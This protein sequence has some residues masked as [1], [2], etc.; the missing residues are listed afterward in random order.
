MK[1]PGKLKGC[2]GAV[3]DTM[4]IIYL[5]ENHEKYG[6]VVEWLL[7]RAEAGEFQGLITPVT[8]AEIL[9]KPLRNGRNDLADIYRQSFVN[10]ENIKLCAMTFKTGAMAGALRAKY[11]L[12]L[13]DMF[14]A[15]C[16][17]EHGGVLITNDVN[18]RKI[19]DIH[20]VILS[21]I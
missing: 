17:L 6:G 9:V 19:S 13:P 16:A 7:Q 4:L 14:Q 2:R 15:A 18:L 21:E 11:G 1:L 20:V 12:P 5:F 8:M 3:L 10:A